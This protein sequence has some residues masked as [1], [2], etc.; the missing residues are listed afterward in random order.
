VD[1]DAFAVAAAEATLAANGQ[2]GRV[3]ASDGLSAVGG[4]FRTIISNPPFHDGIHT[5][6]GM[7]RGFIRDMARHLR[8]DG[9]LWLV[10]N[11]FLPYADAMAEA[12]GEVETAAANSRF[13]LYRAR[14]RR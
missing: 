7:T 6:Y 3:Y 10:A 4:G 1:S 14:P 2:A 5:D 13:V 8:P 11:R 12:L 9:E